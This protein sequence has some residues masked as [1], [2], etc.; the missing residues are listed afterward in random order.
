MVFCCQ[1]VEIVGIEGF[2]FFFGDVCDN[3]FVLGCDFVFGQCFVGF[4]YFCLLGGQVYFDIVVE[5]DVGVVFG[6]VGCDGYCIGNIGFGYDYGFL[7]VIVSIEDL[8]F[9]WDQFDYV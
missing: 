5:L 6:Y 3:F 2:L 4:F 8:V 7:F 1:Y 9:D